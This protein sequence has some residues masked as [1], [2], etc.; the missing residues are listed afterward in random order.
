MTF[1]ETFN[2]LFLCFN[3]YFDWFYVLVLFLCFIPL[4][5]AFY[6]FF[7]YGWSASTK[8]ERHN[9]RLGC[10]LVCISI[11]L[12]TI[13]TVAY[14]Y[15]LYG[16]QGVYEGI[17]DMDEWGNYRRTSKRNYIIWQILIGTTELALFTYFWFACSTW[18]NIADDAA[19]EEEGD[20][21][22][23]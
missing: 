21:E 14:I 13:W 4:Y 8:D 12:Y 11:I 19:V 18:G 6:L 3:A 7:R 23:K 9:L 15:V 20:K 2:A 17:G 22:N 1:S 16:Y 5:I 10:L